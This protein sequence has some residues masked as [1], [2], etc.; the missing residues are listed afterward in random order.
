MYIALFTAEVHTAGSPDS[1]LAARAPFPAGF[2]PSFPN[3][4]VRKPQSKSIK[5]AIIAYFF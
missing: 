2:P 4:V 3:S 5:G 1:I